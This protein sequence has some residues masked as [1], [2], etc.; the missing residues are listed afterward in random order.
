MQRLVS[1][2]QF[3]PYLEK[4]RETPSGPGDVMLAMVARMCKI[5]LIE[6]DFMTKN[7]AFPQ[8]TRFGGRMSHIHYISRQS[9]PNLIELLLWHEENQQE[10]RLREKN[11]EPVVLTATGEIVTQ[12]PV[13]QELFWY[14]KKDR[15]VLIS[16]DGEIMDL[17]EKNG[18]TYRGKEFVLV[19]EEKAYLRM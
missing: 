14:E 3:K 13:L 9:K 10:M 8:M 6:A 11:G 15:I 19:P 5:Y 2:P 18:T 17:L 16:G 4:R 12:H 7:C 1:H